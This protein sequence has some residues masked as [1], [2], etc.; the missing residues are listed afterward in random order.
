MRVDPAASIQLAL[1]G[2]LKSSRGDAAA[3]PFRA[4]TAPAAP[5]A[6][7]L[8]SPT[9]TASVAMLVAVAAQAPDAHRRPTLRRAERGLGAL[10]RLHRAL[11][12]GAVPAADLAELRDWSGASLDEQ[13]ELAALLRDIELRVLVE[14]A[15]GER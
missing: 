14:L 7:P 13:G 2:L 1:L 8:T 15:K 3:T 9:P 4:E 11:A 6:P 10:E 12:I 5:L